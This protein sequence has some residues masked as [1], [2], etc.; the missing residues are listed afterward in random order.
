MPLKKFPV[1]IEFFKL[2][3]HLGGIFVNW[4]Q[5][6]FTK[7]PPIWVEIEFERLDFYW[8]FFFF[9]FG[10]CSSKPELV[11]PSPAVVK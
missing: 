11:F 1:E 3:F 4:K 8:Y 5:S 9:F 6:L 10:S 2:D 7:M